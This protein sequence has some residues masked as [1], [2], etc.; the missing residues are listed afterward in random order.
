MKLLY[1]IREFLYPLLEGDA[2]TEPVAIDDDAL[3][4][5]DEGL[6][7]VYEIALHN[8]EAEEKRRDKV[9]TKSS[10]FIGTTS[11]IT[12]VTFAATAILFKT[13]DQSSFPVLLALLLLVFLIY[14]TRTIW[15][16][17]KALERKA[18]HT[19]SHREL[20]DHPTKAT[21]TKQLIIKTINATQKNYVPTN[22]K[23]DY[24]TMAQEYYKRAIAVFV[25]YFIFLFGSYIL[26]QLNGFKID[27]YSLSRNIAKLSHIH[28]I[29]CV[30]LL[31]NIL[32]AILLI[33]KI[34]KR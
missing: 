6:E 30:S 19:V 14:L 32:L 25:I 13:D 17:I 3:K 20:L 21:L 7:K 31:L 2:P 12:T 18:Y 1:N 4:I 33:W 9:E 5:D 29:T 27:Y 28:W 22:A 34:K 10:I 8:Y 26:S 11:I 16:S 15:F 24:M 23:V